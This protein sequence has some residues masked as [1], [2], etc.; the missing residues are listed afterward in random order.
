MVRDSHSIH[1]EKI[2]SPTRAAIESAPS[3]GLS[4]A[5]LLHN[6]LRAEILER[7]PDST[8]ETWVM[9]VEQNQ[10]STKDKNSGTDKASGKFLAGLKGVRHWNWFYLTH[11]WTAPEARKQGFAQRLIQELISRAREENLA[12]IYVDTFDAQ[13][14]YLK[15]GFQMLGQLPGFPEGGV[16]SW[17]YLKL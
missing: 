6:L 14:F 13:E 4:R 3:E 9:T 7:W 17:L 11:L 10:T 5:E 8:L 16:R 1:W 15:L 2:K 12:G